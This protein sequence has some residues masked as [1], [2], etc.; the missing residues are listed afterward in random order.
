MKEE[1]EAWY[2]QFVGKPY[3]YFKERG[4]CVRCHNQ[5]AAKGHSHCLNCLDKR[6]VYSIKRYANL[7]DE[8]RTDEL[9]RSSESFK[10]RYHNRKNNGMCVRCNKR[11]AR[12]DRTMCIYCAIKA[13]EQSRL[14]RIKH[15]EEKV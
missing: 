14:Y 5:K 12:E 2:K 1:K 13:M 15:S 9:N 8:Q 11:P 3:S 7:T 4:L 6:S 10:K